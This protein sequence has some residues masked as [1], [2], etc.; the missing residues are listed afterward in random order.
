MRLAQFGFSLIACAALAYFPSPSFA[1]DAWCNNGKTVKLP[2]Q[3]I[4]IVTGDAT[5]GTRSKGAVVGTTLVPTLYMPLGMPLVNAPTPVPAPAPANGIAATDDPA[6]GAAMAAEHHKLNQARNQAFFN[7]DLQY[8]NDLSKR[9]GSSG[10]APSSATT[11]T[12]IA[13]Q[14]Q[15]IITTLKNIDDR[16][17]AVEKMLLVHDNYLKELDNKGVNPN[18]TPIKK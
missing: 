14:V 7:A 10:V 15:T 18:M 11:D 2:G 4:T 12:T 17:T 6:L 8:R 5:V 13:N 1:W 16:L 3:K 9:L